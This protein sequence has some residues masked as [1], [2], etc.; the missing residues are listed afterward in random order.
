MVCRTRFAP[1]PTG[2]L[3]LGHA[4]AAWVAHDVAAAAGGEMLLRFEDLDEGRVRPEFYT[5]IEEDLKWLGIDWCEKP[6]VQS[7]RLIDYRQTLDAL[8]KLDVIYPCFC[9]RREILEEFARMGAAPHGGSGP[10]YPGT[11]RDLTDEQREMRFAERGGS[12]VWRLNS[13]AAAKR[14]GPLWFDDLAHGR[15]RVRPDLLGDVVLARKE[16]GIAYHLAVVVDDAYQKISHVTRGDD[17]LESTHVHCMLQKLLG[18]STP[19][20]LHHPLCTDAAGKRLAKRHDAMSLAALRNEGKRP[21]QLRAE[22]GPIMQSSVSCI[23][24]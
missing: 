8:K 9:T 17:L 22:L 18:F 23:T 15:I 10:I 24:G 7:E 3:H 13:A 4:L 1:S 19:T 11:C 20:Y 12:H 16:G 6:M 5:Q 21:E 2:R 14:C